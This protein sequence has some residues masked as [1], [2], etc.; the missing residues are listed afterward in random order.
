M[1]IHT[2]G[3]TEPLHA[4]DVHAYPTLSQ[5][6]DAYRAWVMRHGM[7]KRKRVPEYDESGNTK[8]SVPRA[9]VARPPEAFVTSPEPVSRNEHR[10]TMTAA[11]APEAHSQRLSRS[12]NQASLLHH[13]PRRRDSS[14]P[15]SFRRTLVSPQSTPSE[16]VSIPSTTGRT[17]VNPASAPPSAWSSPRTSAEHP[18]PLL[19]T[20]KSHYL[21]SRP[22]IDLALQGQENAQPKALKHKGTF[23]RLRRLSVS[24]F[25]G[26][27]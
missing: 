4:Q 1:N 18:P 19:K 27:K 12:I 5:H 26:D 17:S 23:S 25:V 6:D 3:K 7:D 11:V 14:A 8:K 21:K 13:S 22:S 24:L 9:T 20:R 16:C 10:R 2:G 15:S